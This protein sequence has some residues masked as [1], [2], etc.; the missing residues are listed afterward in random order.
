MDL[1][2]KCFCG[3]NLRCSQSEDRW[4]CPN[5]HEVYTCKNSKSGGKSIPLQWIANYQRWYRYECQQYV[6]TTH[7]RDARKEERRE[8]PKENLKELNRALHV[9]SAVNDVETV[10]DLIEHGA[11]VNARDSQGFTPLIYATNNGCAD[12]VQLLIA[13]GVDVNL[14]NNNN[15]TALMGA[16]HGAYI[17]II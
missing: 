3:V 4:W 10:K 15:W 6:L 7:T 13:H 1:D 11:G 16:T 14:P 12:T 2:Y 8:A 17:E 9:P 5:A